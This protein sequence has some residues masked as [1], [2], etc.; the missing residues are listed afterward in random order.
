MPERYSRWFD[1]SLSVWKWH[2]LSNDY[3]ANAGE[4]SFADGRA[5]VR[6]WKSSLSDTPAN[7]S[8]AGSSA[9]QQP[10]LH[11]AD[12]EYDRHHKRRFAV[13]SKGQQLPHPTNFDSSNAETFKC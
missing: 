6:P 4:F 7:V 8:V 2:H 1:G 9:P 10:G 13:V 3:H 11:L 12:N 5:L